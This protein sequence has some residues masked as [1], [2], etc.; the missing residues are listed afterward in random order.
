MVHWGQTLF[1]FASS[2]HRLGGF[3]RSRWQRVST[4]ATLGTEVWRRWWR[5]INEG[6]DVMVTSLF[7]STVCI[8]VVGRGSPG[9][10][11]I[12]DNINQNIE[13]LNTV[14]DATNIKHWYY[15]GWGPKICQIGVFDVENCADVVIVQI[16]YENM[17]KLH[18]YTWYWL[19][20]H[21]EIGNC[22]FVTV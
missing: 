22:I 5:I 7:L 16:C 1:I 14:D 4:A 8:V 19:K 10:V 6:Q 20:A 17:R 12:Y 15:L 21:Y 13:A 11:T 3:E 9:E 18:S 2:S